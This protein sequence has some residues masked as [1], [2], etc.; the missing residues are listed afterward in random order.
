[1]FSPLLCVPSPTLG[2]HLWLRG[3]PQQVH[4]PGPFS[5]MALG[6]LGV[7]SVSPRAPGQEEQGPRPQHSLTAPGETVRGLGY[8]GERTPA[9]DVV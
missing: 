4:H 2:P 8:P 6:L 7:L 9:P 1:M 5:A 3:V